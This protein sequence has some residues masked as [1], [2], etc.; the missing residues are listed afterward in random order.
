[1]CSVVVIVKI[2]IPIDLIDAFK[3]NTWK[4][5]A[6]KSKKVYACDEVELNVE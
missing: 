1:M 6:S 3:I 4:K 5:C 2:L